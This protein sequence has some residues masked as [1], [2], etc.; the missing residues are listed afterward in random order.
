VLK[1]SINMGSKSIK[2]RPTRDVRADGNPVLKAEAIVARA[3][4]LIDKD[5]LETFS[6]RNLAASLNVFPTTIY[7]HMDHK[8]EVLAQVVVLVLRDVLPKVKRRDWQQFLRDV[9][10]N[11]RRAIRNHP[12]VAPLIAAQIVPNTALSLEFIERVL[13]NLERAGLSGQA[14]VSGYNSV[15]AALVGFAAQEFAPVPADEREAWQA[16]VA[17]RVAG[18]SADAYPV[19][20]R[21]LPLLSNRAFMLRWQ[22]GVDAPLDMSYEFYVEAVIA[23][24]GQIARRAKRAPRRV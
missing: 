14:L 16:H 24:I 22:N 6:V 17:T 20:A 8:N 7:W 1:L 21:H 19:L 9:F 10:A 13:A 15:I 18:I 3:L 12:N 23:G 5:G 2:K 4:E 11:F